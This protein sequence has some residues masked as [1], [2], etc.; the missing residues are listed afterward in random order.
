[1][2]ISRVG[3]STT[4]QNREERSKM[5]TGAPAG[6]L[7]TDVILVQPYVEVNA[8]P[9]SITSGTSI[10]AQKQVSTLWRTGAFWL[11]GTVS[12]IVVTWEG[13]ETKGCTCLIETWRGINITSPIASVNAF[14]E[15]AATEVTINS[16]ERKF[17][18][19]FELITGVNGTLAEFLKETPSGWSRDSGNSPYLIH[20][21]FTAT[22]ASG[23]QVVKSNTAAAQVY[24][25]FAWQPAPSLPTPARTA[26]NFLLR[27]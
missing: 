21:A 3:S 23:T 9:I 12:T 6:T 17:A 26:R 24:L 25:R 2:A 18:P 27:R 5:E 14:Q 13:S 1:M 10:T 15:A 8:K 22:G 7:A 11:P 20:R 16:L 19:S 4:F